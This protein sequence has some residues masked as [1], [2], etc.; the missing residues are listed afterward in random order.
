MYLLECLKLD[1]YLCALLH[2]EKTWFYIQGIIATYM[3]ALWEIATLIIQHIKSSL[4]NQNF[5]YYLKAIYNPICSIFPAL[6][7]GL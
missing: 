6:L 2:L 4:K 3:N 1:K 7:K 5:L